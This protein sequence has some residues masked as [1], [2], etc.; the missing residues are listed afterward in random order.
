MSES[1][2]SSRLNRYFK[3]LEKFEEEYDIIQKYDITDE[4]TQ[5]ALMYSLQICVEVSMDIVAMIVKDIGA[6]V[7][8]DYSN[9]KTLTDKKILS[10]EDAALL[11]LYNGL[12]IEQNSSSFVALRSFGAPNAIVHKYD[13]IN[14]EVVKDG[15]HGIDEV[16]EIIIKLIEAFEKID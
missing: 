9:I 11:K 12:R 14:L 15:L 10:E 7:E 13:N 4:I 1:K 3:K 16:Y 2:N 6:V 8:D 5:R